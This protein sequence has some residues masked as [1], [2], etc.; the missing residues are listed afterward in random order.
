MGEGGEEG[1]RREREGEG[2]SNY[3]KHKDVSG[4]NTGCRVRRQSAE[5]DDSE[6]LGEHSI[7]VV[8]QRQTTLS[9]TSKEM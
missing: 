5:Q 9:E 4:S 6:T 1:R 2:E 3:T 8:G 7:K